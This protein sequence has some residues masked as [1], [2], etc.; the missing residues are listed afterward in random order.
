MP[1]RDTS[2]LARVLPRLRNDFET[3]RRLVTRAVERAARLAD[4]AIA[5]RRLLAERTQT[6]RN[7][8]PPNAEIWNAAA[9]EVVR[10]SRE[11][12]R[13]LGVVAHEL[14]QS[15][16]AALAAERLLAVG[17]NPTAQERARAVLSRQLLHLAE[18]VDSLLDY[19]RL[20]LHSATVPM[21]RVD[22]ADVVGGAVETVSA[23]AAER[24]HQ[25]DLHGAGAPVV[26]AG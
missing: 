21:R 17:V 9:R 7:G 10:V 4:E 3:S 18:L 13:E 16:S 26:V 23:A 1:G 24:R 14:R 20:S 5:R 2:E 12:D 8:A 19:S 6:P 25:I 15:L 22:L 11:R